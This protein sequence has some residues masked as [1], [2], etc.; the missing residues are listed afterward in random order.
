M[1]D[2][3]DFQLLERD[4]HPVADLLIEAGQRRRGNARR[5][6]TPFP[7]RTLG[8]PLVRIAPPIS[9][10]ILDELRLM[11]PQVVVARGGSVGHASFEASRER[12]SPHLRAEQSFAHDTNLMALRTRRLSAAEPSQRQPQDLDA[13]PSIRRS[14]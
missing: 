5:C 10:T 4:V 2:W 8:S 1:G 14:R 6:G 9:T 3:R 11:G 12:G 13:M 7:T